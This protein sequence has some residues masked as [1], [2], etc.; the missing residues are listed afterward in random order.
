MKNKIDII[1]PCYNAHKTLEQA[2]MSIANQSI[3]DKLKIYIINDNSKKDYSEIIQ[4]FKIFIDITEYKLDS[5]HGPGYARQYGINHS[6][7]DRIMFLDSDD[8]FFSFS[9]I[10]ALDK[11]MEETNCDMVFSNILDQNEYGFDL[12][13]NDWIDIQGKLYSRDFINKHNIDFPSLYGEEDNSFNQQFYAFDPYIEIINDITYVRLINK[14]S[15]TRSNSNDYYSKYEQYFSNGFKYTLNKL[16]SNNANKETIAKKAFFAIV[17]LYNRIEIVYNGEYRNDEVFSNL[18]EII[19]IYNK[20]NEY[21][22][23]EDKEQII[24]KENGPAFNYGDLLMNNKKSISE[25]I[26]EF[27]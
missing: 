20:Y 17:R 21:I 3:K 4:K 18:K 9:S 27:K 2:L 7:N 24:I 12:L 19:K 26:D 5:N 6:S 15:L 14:D 8:V 16:I 25:F 22:S 10:E 23:K 11:K 13:E 1:I